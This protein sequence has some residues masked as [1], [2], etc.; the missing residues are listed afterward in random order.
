MGDIV[1][2]IPTISLYKKHYPDHQVYYVVEENF[3]EIAQ[4]IPGIDHLMVIPRKMG[5]RQM[6]KFRQTVREKGIDT[7]VDLHSGPKSAQLTFISHVP[8]R[9][10]YHSPH[11]DW[12]Y[13]RLIPRRPDNTLTHSVINQAKLLEPLGIPIH[14]DT[15]LSYPTITINENTC[16]ISATLKETL[17]HTP[18]PRAV[19]HVGAGNA[20]RDWGLDKF[21][22]L[23]E[24]LKANHI[25]VF[26][27][28]NGRD[29]QTRAA[30]LSERYQIPDFCG[31]LSIAQLIYL[32]THSQV[33][34]GADSG[35]L[36]VAS[37]TPTPLVALYGPNIP[38]ISGPWRNKNV[39]IIRQTM[40]CQP[41]NQRTCIYDIIPCMKNI[42][43]ED[44]YEAIIQYIQ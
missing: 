36:H 30:H 6:W 4:L 10:G 18:P 7:I 39:S 35:P 28:G 3:Q 11:R 14:P 12:A 1:F 31:K 26:L 32:I 37:L 16:P 5:L 19:I 13:T 2:T 8:T 20:F 9:I 38:G 24:K 41:C 34:V 42:K 33:Y 23:I 29:E 27:I 22:G 43:T 25:T 40:D 17:T 15:P 44:V 21:S